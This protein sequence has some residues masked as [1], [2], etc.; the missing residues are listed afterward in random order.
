MCFLKCVLHGMYFI[1]LCIGNEAV[2]FATFMYSCMNVICTCS[3]SQ[4]MLYL[5]FN[6]LQESQNQNS[7]SW[8]FG[9]PFSHVS[10]GSSDGGL[11]TSASAPDEDTATSEG[12]SSDSEDR[13]QRVRCSPS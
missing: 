5:L 3:F 6:A 9:T 11:R 4:F 7:P 2:L 8:S 13:E 12:S 10:H 1:V